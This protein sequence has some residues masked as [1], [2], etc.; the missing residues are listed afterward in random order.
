MGA[1]SYFCSKW[2]P[3]HLSSFSAANSLVQQ[4]YSVLELWS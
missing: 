3:L 2:R 4:D 1:M